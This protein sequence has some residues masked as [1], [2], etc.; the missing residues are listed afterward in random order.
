MKK[1]LSCLLVMGTVLTVRAE[2]WGLETSSLT[3]HVKHTLHTVEG[4]STVARGKGIC[5]EEGC[6]FLVA[7]PVASFLSGD[8]NRD[9]HMM[10]TTRGASFPMVTVSV[11][12]PKVPDTSPFLADLVIEFS[13]H[14]ATYAAVPFAVIDRSGDLL[15][16]TGVVPL[17]IDDFKIPA[18]S[19]LGMAIKREVPV[20]IEM[21]WRRAPASK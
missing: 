13:G 6:R 15:R 7:A 5:Q 17:N 16:F 8:T 18:P 10:E 12:L 19:L 21:S 4:T 3:Y 11:A 20:Q 14:K 9:L 1:I 2:N